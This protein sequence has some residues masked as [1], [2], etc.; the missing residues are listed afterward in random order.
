MTSRNNTA[1]ADRHLGKWTLQAVAASVCRRKPAS[2]RTS[3]KTA[4]AKDGNTTAHGH[5]RRRYTEEKGQKDLRAVIPQSAQQRSAQGREPKR[6]LVDDDTPRRAGPI[7]AATF[8]P[9]SKREGSDAHALPASIMLAEKLPTK[10][11]ASSK[12][13]QKALPLF[14]YYYYYYFSESRSES[15]SA[16]R[17]HHAKS[18]SLPTTWRA[19]NERTAR[20]GSRRRS[21][22]RPDGDTPRDSALFFSAACSTS[23]S[24]FQRFALKTRIP[25]TLKRPRHREKA[26]V[27]L[28]AVD[29]S[30]YVL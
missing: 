22:R 13:G 16:R 23:G 12:H 25:L 26:T 2:G 21:E 7:A 14:F 29:E 24:F 28:P 19:A 1:D 27:F 3:K 6:T 30:G 11:T 10:T 9:T 5:R 18:L 17:A 20:R 8:P 15:T 4:A